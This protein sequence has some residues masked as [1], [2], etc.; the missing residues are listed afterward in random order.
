MPAGRSRKGGN[1]PRKRVSK[2]QSSLLPRTPL[3]SQR[4]GVASRS[5]SLDQSSASVSFMSGAGSSSASLKGYN[6]SGSYGGELSHLIIA[7][8]VLFFPKS[9]HQKAFQALC[10]AKERIL[11]DLVECHCLI[12]FPPSRIHVGFMALLA[13]SL[14]DPLTILSFTSQIMVLH[15]IN[16]G[17]PSFHTHLLIIL[18]HPLHHCNHQIMMLKLDSLLF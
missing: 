15:H 5:S 9:I 1:P 10:M 17:Q 16:N 12:R 6:T 11:R 4:E 3:S 2:S 8:K 7:V 13:V 18:Q 14:I